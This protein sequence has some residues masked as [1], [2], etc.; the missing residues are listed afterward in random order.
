[1]LRNLII[2]KGMGILVSFFKCHIK[3]THSNLDQIE[4]D[5]I[6]ALCSQFNISEGVGVSRG[7]RLSV[8]W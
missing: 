5:N 8:M 2:L 6:F 3:R 7:R 1:M 4:A